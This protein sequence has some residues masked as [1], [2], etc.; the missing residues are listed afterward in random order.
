[1]ASMALFTP[2]EGQ[3]ERGKRQVGWERNGGLLELY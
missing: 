1:M 2:V 3:N